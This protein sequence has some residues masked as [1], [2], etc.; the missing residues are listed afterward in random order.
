MSVKV[1]PVN[2][3]VDVEVGTLAEALPTLAALIGL[4][5]S[6]HSLMNEEFGALAEALP[7]LATGVGLL[8]SVHPEVD[9][10]V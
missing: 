10:Q 4:L 1:L 2:P 5:S 9:S 8:S 3:L 6:V 7:T